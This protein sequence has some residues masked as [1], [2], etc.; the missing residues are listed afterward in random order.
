[1]LWQVRRSVPPF[2]Q[3]SLARGFYS[4]SPRARHPDTVNLALFSSPVVNL[5]V[6]HDLRPK[7]VDVGNDKWRTRW[8]SMRRNRRTLYNNEEVIFYI[9][10]Q[11]NEVTLVIGKAR[12]CARAPNRRSK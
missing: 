9:I 8:R 7:K 12:V 6:E 11:P 2:P 4:L 1:M 10:L 5:D 3:V